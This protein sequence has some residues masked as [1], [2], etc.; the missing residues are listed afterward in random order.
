MNSFTFEYEG[1]RP[2]NELGYW[3]YHTD[4]E[5]LQEGGMSISVELL[6]KY[7]AEKVCEA[8]DRI[9]NASDH[10]QPSLN[11]VIESIRKEHEQPNTKV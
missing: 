1:L 6:N 2:M 10:T 7:A 3:H 9:D 5:G 11:D 4:E 8:L